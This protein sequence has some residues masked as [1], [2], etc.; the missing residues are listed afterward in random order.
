MSTRT[1]VGRR[2]FVGSVAAGLPLLAGGAAVAQSSRGAAKGAAAKAEALSAKVLRQM[3]REQARAFHESKLG[4]AR[5][6][7]CRLAAA[8]L[9]LVASLEL[10]DLVRQGARK[11]AKEHQ[12]HG[13]RQGL[14][15]LA[16]ELKKFGVD[17]SAR[18]LEQVEIWFGEHPEAR[19]EA[20]QPTFDFSAAA[21][22]LSL[23]LE[24]VE[25][26]IVP[27]G[28]PQLRRVLSADECRAIAYNLDVLSYATAFLCS[29]GN[30]PGCLFAGTSIL[31]IAAVAY[32]AGC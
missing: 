3:A 20:S 8:N 6:E 12:Q 31:L 4:G 13:K 22:R 21:L 25:A 19:D 11:S 15:M 17:T 30:A 32:G 9:R 14:A 2:V 5:R 28:T 24:K 7:H 29:L 18:E 10:D 26:Q 16:P 23:A 1:E 27:P